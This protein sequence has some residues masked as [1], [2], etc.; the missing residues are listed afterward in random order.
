MSSWRQELYP[1]EGGVEQ[2]VVIVD[3][4]KG[5]GCFVCPLSN[6]LHS[7]LENIVFV[8]YSLQRQGK[9]VASGLREFLLCVSS[10]AFLSYRRACFFVERKINVYTYLLLLLRRFRGA[11]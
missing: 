9:W 7:E 4:S 8:F 2:K 3:A 1:L 6:T 5:N 10:F 11:G